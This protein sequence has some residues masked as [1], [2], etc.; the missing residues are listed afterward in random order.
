MRIEKK[1]LTLRNGDE[2]MKWVDQDS[3][4]TFRR[5]RGALGWPHA[6]R[7]GFA[8]VLGEDFDPGHR[9]PHSPRHYRI[10]AEHETG[11]LEELQRHCHQFED[12]FCLKSFLGNPEN[13]IHEIWKQ[14]AGHS[15]RIALP[16]DHEKIDLN[17]LA[18][19][20]KQNT[21]ARKTLH[22]GES[23]IPGFLT[24]F[25][26]DRIE[27]EQIEQFPPMAAF[28]FALAQLALS[29]VPPNFHF[30]PDRSAAGRRN[31]RIRRRF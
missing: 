17:L 24:R 4:M 8:L 5:I 15:T 21:E 31:S 9:L 30:V 13:P 19:L 1:E 16:Y 20:V 18:Q 11:D 23:K 27:N 6:E 28:G 26:A 22:F 25:M 14:Q 10:L 2:I 7:P 12:E 29:P 3:D